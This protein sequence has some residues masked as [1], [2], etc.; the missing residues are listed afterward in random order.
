MP[1]LEE[2]LSDFSQNPPEAE[3]G[4]HIA[5]SKILEKSAEYASPPSF[6]REDSSEILNDPELDAS[7][8]VWLSTAAQVSVGSRDF[9]LENGPDVM[10]SSDEDSPKEEHGEV[11]TGMYTAGLEAPV[12]LSQ[13]EVARQKAA[14]EAFKK[15]GYGKWIDSDA[16]ASSSSD[17]AQS[18]PSSP[19][20][21][22]SGSRFDDSD[23]DP[24][25]QIA[26]AISIFETSGRS[27]KPAA[28]PRPSTPTASVTSPDPPKRSGKRGKKK[29]ATRLAAASERAH[30]MATR[31]SDASRAGSLRPG[32]GGTG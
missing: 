29:A 19:A 16:P 5:L 20:S 22:R 10:N 17:F 11:L 21:T 12:L 24:P 13:S 3:D 4:S 15:A 27:S 14:A 6:Y 18:A 1:Q 2:A 26:P 30:P 31:R 32:V 23:P 25:S 8:P 9:V 28:P 7:A